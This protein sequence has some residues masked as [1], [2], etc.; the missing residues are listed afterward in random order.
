MANIR[1]FKGC[2]TL[3]DVR[4]LLALHI[5]NLKPES[6]SYSTMLR[7]YEEAYKEYSDKHKNRSGKIYIQPVSTSPERFRKFIE[8]MLSY[9]GVTVERVG[10]WYHIYG[11]T[12][13]HKDEI[14]SFG[15]GWRWR[16]EKWKWHDG[17][18]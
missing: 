3:E 17:A 7:Q 6:K 8:T 9:E 15:A 11:E 4:D 16:E 12:K 14:R 13:P 5:Q 1:Y 2:E 10:T 18:A